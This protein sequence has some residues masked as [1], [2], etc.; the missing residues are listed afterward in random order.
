MLLR[1]E[2][3]RAALQRCGNTDAAQPAIDPNYN[4]NL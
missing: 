2:V 3:P 1:R 4:E